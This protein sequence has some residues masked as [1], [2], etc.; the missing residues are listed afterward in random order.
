MVTLLSATILVLS[1]HETARAETLIDELDFTNEREV[2]ENNRILL[3][4]NTPSKDPEYFPIDD[5]VE[6]EPTPVEPYTRILPIW[7]DKAREKGYDLPLPF[8][9][10]ANA[11]IQQVRPKIEEL[12]FGLGT[13]KERPGINIEGSKVT[14]ATLIGRADMWL[15]PFLN[16]Y[17]F[18]GAIK[19]IMDINVNVAAF[20]TDGINIPAFS[21]N[22]NDDYNGAT[23]GVGLTLAGGYKEFFG[24]LDTNYA[25]T[26]LDFLNG[27]VDVFTTT[28]RV[29][30]RINSE[31]YGFGNV[32]AGVMYIDMR[33]R[34]K[35]SIMV[36]TPGPIRRELHYDL[37]FTTKDKYTLLGGGMWEF[38]QKVQAMVEVGVGGRKSLLG[39]LSYRF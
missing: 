6:D 33:E 30:M 20:T 16:V 8:G 14:S 39:S 38:S 15:F 24:T 11:M 34:L 22:I 36:D 9:V 3:A 21:L 10:A 4:T 7:G 28:P 25:K 26:Y 13:P 17:G 23:G 19:G 2:S 1:A 32:W 12:K 18:G 29:G 31:K 37:Y 35:G 27:K 5:P